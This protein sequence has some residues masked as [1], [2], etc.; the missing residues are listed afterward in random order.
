MGLNKRRRSGNL[1]GGSKLIVPGEP[2]FNV[3]KFETTFNK[4]GSTPDNFREF[5]PSP[6]PI[7]DT[8]YIL[9]QNIEV[10][11]TQSGDRLIWI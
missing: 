11:T 8:F 2:I 5:K 6:P 9:T 1:I 7:I 4:K 3:K 10:V